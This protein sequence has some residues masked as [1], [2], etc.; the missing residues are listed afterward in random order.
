MFL[1]L[2]CLIGVFAGTPALAG[3]NT[4]PSREPFP[5]PN[6]TMEGCAA[7]LTVPYGL[8]IFRSFSG[9]NNNSSD[10]F[11]MKLVATGIYCTPALAGSNT[12]PSGEPF[13]K[14]SKNMEACAAKLT[15]P[16]GLEIFCSFSG[17]N[18]NPSN[19]CCEKLVATGIYCHN[20]FTDILISKEPQENP[21]KIS[22]R[23]MDIWNHC[24]VVAS[25]A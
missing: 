12:A 7:K 25:K 6:K 8:E 11:C 18:N 3:S 10:D 19:N 22:L 16:C 17:N 24:V 21:S 23:S 15:V 20:A 14:P 9:N 1:V 5:K 2:L 13:P 4:A